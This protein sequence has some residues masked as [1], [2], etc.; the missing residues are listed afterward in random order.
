MARSGWPSSCELA[1]FV[2][3]VETRSGGNGAS[4]I[5]KGGRPKM[6]IFVWESWESSQRNTR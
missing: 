4:G 3:Q 6:A 1:I 5:R 2:G